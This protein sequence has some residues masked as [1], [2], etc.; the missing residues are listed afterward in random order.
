MCNLRTIGGNMK[1]RKRI[2]FIVCIFIFVCFAILQMK[3]ILKA[4]FVF[5]RDYIDYINSDIDHQAKLFECIIGGICAGGVTFGALFISILH[6]N[7]KDQMFWERER[8]KEREDRLLSI[9][10]F[11]NIEVKTVSLVRTD[12]IDG[13]ENI[14]IVGERDS[15]QYA[16][17]VLSNNGYGRCKDIE[18][19]GRK[20]SVSQLDVDEKQKLKIFFQGIQDG[21]NEFSMFFCYKDIFG[22]VYL[23]S[24][25]CKLLSGSKELYIA[26]GESLLNGG[27]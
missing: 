27:E 24:F 16:N 5:L 19:D 10:P 23:Q 2:I 20:C 6:E 25:I 3:G 14:V 18:L 13:K 7:K 15:Y 1:Y 22:N 17:I 9:R 26:I 8:K 21:E 4:S 12:T 11:L